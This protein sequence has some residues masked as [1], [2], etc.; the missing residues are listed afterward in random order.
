[1]FGRLVKRSRIK[2]PDLFRKKKGIDERC[3]IWMRRGIADPFYSPFLEKTLGRNE[4]SGTLHLLSRHADNVVRFHYFSNVMN[5]AAKVLSKCWG[6][7]WKGAWKTFLFATRVTVREEK[8]FGKILLPGRGG[9]S[10]LFIWRERKI[11]RGFG[12]QRDKYRRAL[13][14]ESEFVVGGGEIGSKKGSRFSF[15]PAFL[16]S[17]PL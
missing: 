11:E 2:I 14:V 16:S 12:K 1:M 3:D 10:V 9:I 4:S 5:S 8:F 6:F 17:A 7:L 15:D 13:P